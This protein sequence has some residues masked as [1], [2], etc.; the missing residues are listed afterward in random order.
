MDAV[1][2]RQ[3]LLSG[4]CVDDLMPLLEQLSS[5]LSAFTN[6]EPAEAE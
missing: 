3:I 2:S 4:S 6:R 5:G 1:L